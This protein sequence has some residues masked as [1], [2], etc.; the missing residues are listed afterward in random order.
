MSRDTHYWAAALAGRSLGLL[1]L[2]LCLLLPLVSWAGQSRN[3]KHYKPTGVPVASPTPQPVPPTIEFQ[4][5]G[6]RERAERDENIPVSLFISN[7]TAI[8]VT[9]LKLIF[10]HNSFETVKQPALP[11]SLAAFDSVTAE[12]VIKPRN[13]AGYETHKLLFTLEYRWKDGDKEFRSA[14]SATSAVL[15]QRRFE[16]ETKGFPGGTAAFFYLLLPIIPAILSYQFCDGL[17][18]GE[19]PKLPSFGAEYIVPAFFAAVVLSLLMLFAFRLDSGLNYSNPVIFTSVLFASLL[20]GSVVPLVRWQ[21]ENKLKVV[22][23]FNNTDTFETYLRKALLAPWA[24]REFTWATGRVDRDEWA[25]V[26]LKQPNGISV[27]GAKLQVS[28]AKPLSDDA[29]KLFLQEVISPEGIVRDRARLV[30]MVAA[31]EL[32]LDFAARITH[33][34]NQVDHV[35]IIDE[36]KNWKRAGDQTSPLVTP[37]R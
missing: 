5:L 35:V 27:L 22:W 18:R 28:P 15:V 26:V 30:Q 19:G 33:A 7:K 24:P 4:V 6:A 11:S 3:T 32:Q 23:G 20:I 2:A 29:W 37:Y 31:K 12:I 13:D 1:S 21:H 9:E 10:A 8:T 34:G 36:V 25:G 17:R 16:E 14:Q